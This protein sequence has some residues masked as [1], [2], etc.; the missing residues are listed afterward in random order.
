M[1]NPNKK[2]SRG[3]SPKGSVASAVRSMDISPEYALY[4]EPANPE[5]AE[6]KVEKSQIN[7]NKESDIRFEMIYSTNP[8]RKLNE[9]KKTFKYKTT[10]RKRRRNEST[11][12]KRM[13]PVP[14]ATTKRATREEYLKIAQTLTEYIESDPD[15]PIS[16]RYALE[17]TPKTNAILIMYL[18]DKIIGFATLVFYA[19][20]PS[21]LPEVMFIDIIYGSTK[22]NGVGSQL[23]KYLFKYCKDHNIRKIRLDSITEAI[24][25]YMKK[26]FECDPCSMEFDFDDE[27]DD[28]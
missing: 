19:K 23:M 6:A 7:L 11:T 16:E 1:S 8:M 14:F 12:P 3:I 15:S 20:D 22:Y 5:L 2:R 4:N 21:S 13:R 24:G 17:V 9:V 18:K 28:V 27:E 10:R 26:G 25:F